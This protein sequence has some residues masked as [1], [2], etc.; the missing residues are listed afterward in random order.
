MPPLEN[1]IREGS[2]GRKIEIVFTGHKI[3]GY[4]ED[5][6]PRPEEECQKED[7]VK[8]PVLPGGFAPELEDEIN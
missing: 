7:R 1:N 8:T 5:T 6:H 2:V 4:C 3:G